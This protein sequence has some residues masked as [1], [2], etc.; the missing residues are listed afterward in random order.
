MD[1]SLS[2][3]LNWGHVVVV[4]RGERWS[5]NRRLR[6]LH[7]SCACPAD[8]T[9]RVDVEHPLELVLVNSVIRQ[10]TSSRQVGITWLERCWE[11]RVTCVTDH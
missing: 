3:A 1:K 6:E 9:L 10:F 8:G 2:S 4:P 5:I 11:T 7:I